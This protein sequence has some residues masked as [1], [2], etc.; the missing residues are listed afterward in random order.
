VQP[1]PRPLAEVELVA[2]NGKVTSVTVP[3]A[4]GGG[5][6]SGLSGISPVRVE[7]ADL[8]WTHELD[9]QPRYQVTVRLKDGERL[10]DERH[11]LVGLRTIAL[12]RS[13]DPEGGRHFRF[14]LNGVPIFA[15]GAAWLPAD[16]LVGSVSQRIALSGPAHDCTG[17]PSDNASHL[18]RRH[19]GRRHLRARGAATTKCR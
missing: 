18:G 4:S 17:W 3:L 10:L 2:P 13:R 16:M 5:I 14:V 11:D 12:D 15:R 9:G 8:W 19:L 7:D 6:A 1:G